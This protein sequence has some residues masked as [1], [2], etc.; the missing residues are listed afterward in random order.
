MER[1][2]NQIASVRLGLCTAMAAALL[3]GCAGQSEVAST[4]S[5][6][7]AADASKSDKA[8]VSAEQS[9]SQKM[10]S[11][12][13]RAD[14][15]QAY[16]SVGRFEAAATTFGDAIEL[17]DDS[18]R[19]ALG[20]A[21]AQIGSG[22]G[23]AALVTLEKARNQLP[24]SDYGLA[25]ALA[26]QPARG[27]AVLTDAL[28]GGENTAKMRQ[29]LAYAYALDGRWTEARLMTAQDV[30]ADQVDA[31]IGEWA[32]ESRPDNYR[33][34]IANL[35]GAPLRDDPGQPT[36]LALNAVVDASAP[37]M[38]EA[39]PV[40]PLATDPVV[41]SAP[42]E[43]NEFAAVF[44]DDEKAAAPSAVSQPVVQKV[45]AAP[46]PATT[47]VAAKAAPKP[48]PAKPAAAKPA[49]AKPMVAK[50]DGSYLVQLGSFSSRANAERAQDVYT[51]RH[52]EL[53]GHAFLITEAEVNGRT[54]WRVAV[55]GFEPRS[56]RS[57][58]NS[59][60]SRGGSCIAYAG[61]VRQPG[62]ALASR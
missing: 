22:D 32:R 11:A 3:S 10:R 21:L 61:S 6:E 48:A 62:K 23:N 34:R 59:V 28:R 41:A 42:V 18:S 20:M 17:G 44:A 4:N 12:S 39:E 60:S 58:C 24:A 14:L 40:A 45:A 33:G 19:T 2:F 15:G 54:Y 9:V 1:R 35:I 31:R 7:R 56:A 51:S 50:A 55:S 49:A 25:V 57:F 38:A 53:K 27:V 36:H 46:A 43:Q 16:L 5:S 26:G 47:Q 29:N 37:L 30:P 13:A 8:V 52:P